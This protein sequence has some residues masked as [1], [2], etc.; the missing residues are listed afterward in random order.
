M[1]RF[2]IP[3]LVVAAAIALLALLTFGVSNQGD[4]TS[5]DAQVAK[6]VFPAAPSS[7][8]AL[9]VLGGKRTETLADFRGKV[10]VLNV[11]ASWCGPC[12]A[13]AP[14]LANTQKRI[15]GQNATILGVTYLDNSSDSEQFVRREHV[16]YP[17][18]RD[19]SGS[20]V[21]SFG[22]TG[23]PETFVID[24]QGRVEAVR[25]FQLVGNWLQQTLPPILQ[26]RS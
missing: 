3:S 9:P 20:F 17:V 24:R 16:T 19:V 10:V 12:K 7:N 8:V 22:A 23:V 15:A 26:K 14:I 18:L 21:R 13:E 4:N 6:G 2:V 11:F 5:I 1:R 25:R